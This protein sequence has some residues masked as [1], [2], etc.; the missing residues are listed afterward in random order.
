MV[1]KIMRDTLFLAQKSERAI[2]EDMQV[3]EDLKDTLQANSKTC[4][5]MAANMIGMKKQVIVV[6]LGLAPMVM[7]N[8]K[9]VKKS[10]EYETEEGCLSLEGL[11][12]IKR[13][14][15]ITVEYQDRDFKKQRQDFT[16][17]IAQN[18]Q[19]QCDHIAGVVI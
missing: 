8:P 9:I 4:V 3:A 7:F 12:K 18:I 14:Q 11:R 13:Y 19:H 16:G 15:N 5:G 1:Q 6:S 10:G 17:F 2:K